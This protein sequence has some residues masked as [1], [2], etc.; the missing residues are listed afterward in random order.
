MKQGMAEGETQ[1]DLKSKKS[2]E[3]LKG[4][5]VSLT[6]EPDRGGGGNWYLMDKNTQQDG[7]VGFMSA[8]GKHRLSSPGSVTGKQNLIT[9]WGNYTQWKHHD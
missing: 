4:R 8:A 1:D 2:P 9:G 7:Y 6:V 3:D 5:T